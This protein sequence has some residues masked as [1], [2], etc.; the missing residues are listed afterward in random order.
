MPFVESAAPP[1]VV[2]PYTIPRLPALQSR[3]G[4]L[5]AAAHQLAAGS[6]ATGQASIAAAE[7]ALRGMLVLPGT[8]SKAMFVG[9]PPD[10]FANPVGDIEYTWTL[11][12]MEHWVALLRGW[13]LTE[14]VRYA[15]KVVSELRDWLSRCHRPPIDRSRLGADFNN[16]SGPGTVR[17][18]GKVLQ[19]WPA[20]H[21]AA[22]KLRMGMSQLNNRRRQ[23]VAPAPP[24]LGQTPYN[25]NP[26]RSL[27]AGARMVH[28]WPLLLDLLAD[29]AGDDPAL[30]AALLGSAAE[31]GEVLAEVSPLLWPGAD[32]NHYLMECLGLLAT[33]THFP[34]LPSAARWAAQATA[35]IERCATAQFTPDGGHIEGCPHY[36][37]VCV[38]LLARSVFTANQGGITFSQELHHRLDRSLD[39]CVQTLRPS[40][41][42]VPA[43]D[44][45][46]DQLA[47]QATLFAYLATGDAQ[48]LRR[49][50]H[51]TGREAL[52]TACAEH[53]WHVPDLQ[54]IIT[55][56][57]TSAAIP[58][59]PAP[60]PL[61]CWQRQLKQVTM[62]TDW[63]KQAISCFFS[64]RTPIHN[65]HA[66]ADPASF[67]L[68]ALGVPLL[69]D[70]GRL[71]YAE[72]AA[73]RAI[74][75]AA[76]HNT[77][78]VDGREPFEYLSSMHFGPQRNG[79]ITAVHQQPGLLAAE[80]AHHNYAPATHRRLLA[81]VES[82]AVVV[83]DVLE[84][85]SRSSRAQVYCHVDTDSVCWYDDG[86]TAIGRV[87]DVNV[88]VSVTRN[89]HGHS[90][91]GKVAPMLDAAHDSTRLRFEDQPGARRRCYATV[92]V[93]CPASAAPKA[94]E[95]LRAEFEADS[96]ACSFGMG[97]R[98]YEIDWR[99]GRS[100]GASSVNLAID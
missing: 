98:N 65:G 37:N 92:I 87:A 30:H 35:E 88:I 16:G 74:K 77:L 52:M 60:L 29:L 41:A 15:E 69:V 8:G 94:V 27:E 73:R 72:G 11:N 38:Y 51:F 68:T 6:G 13:L 49:V 21:R 80:A 32:H 33:A 61:L 71:T 84:D 85:V 93:P 96:I 78:T 12:R 47:V 66:H 40:G 62:R 1:P 83:I 63:G 44:S 90:L 76:Y 58:I 48:P 43:G 28:V 14:D 23:R 67:D 25:P 54:Q 46:A 34:Q 53:F 31:H 7:A 26:W 70:P 39:H 81:I 57:T 9:D 50:V 91:P 24:P 42:G 99:P 79:D 36:H 45:D 82:R 97:G 86:R 75:S 17:T 89:L 55:A 19:R 64:C 2:P 100:T 59:D 56:A 10:W 3:H 20:A 22:R 95:G 4:A 18:I 5:R